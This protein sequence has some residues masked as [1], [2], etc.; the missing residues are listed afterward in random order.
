MPIDY[1]KYPP[2]WKK[3][4]VPAVIARAGNKCECCGLENYS[5][6]YAIKPWV[7]NDRG[8]YVIR[9]IWFRDQR[10]AIRE[11]CGHLTVFPIKIILTIAHLDHDELNHAV[12]IDRLMA[13]CQAC[14]LRYDAPE[15]YRREQEKWNLK[16]K[17]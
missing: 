15:K 16:I 3:E 17:T 13:M 2:N 14:H 4:I 10:D 1:A 7:K 12:T 8:K 6:V 9:S 11:S 5:T